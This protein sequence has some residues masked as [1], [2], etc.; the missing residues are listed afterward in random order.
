MRD[1]RFLP[2][3]RRLP[4]QIFR[5]AQQQRGTMLE[6]AEPGV[7]G[8]AQQLAHDLRDVAMINA[9]PIRNFLPA[10]RAA[11]FLALEH[12]VVLFRRNAVGAL[13]PPASR[14]R[15]AARGA[16]ALAIIGIVRI[17]FAR[18]RVARLAAFVRRA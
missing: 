2:R 12:R 14:R 5:G 11:P 7:A 6:A 15:A 18:T 8:N 3:P 4:L 16:V 10:D 13:E 1:T 9:E 17:S